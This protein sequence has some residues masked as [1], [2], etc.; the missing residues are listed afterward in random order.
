MYKK[1]LFSFKSIQVELSKDPVNYID[2]GARG[3]LGEPWNML[4]D[5]SINVIG[6]EPDR[7]AFEV[8]CDKAKS[9][10]KYHNIA[11]W[12]S[13]S[14]LKLYLTKSAAASSVFEPN[15]ELLSST[16]ANRHWNTRAVEST[17]TIAT[18]KL[19]SV[20][21]NSSSD[22]MKVDVHG[23]EFQILEGAK[24]ALK[25]TLGV[26]VEAWALEAH[27]GQRLFGDV[28][29]LLY[30]EGFFLHKINSDYMAW[31][32]INEESYG[33]ESSRQPVGI[34]LFFLKRAELI[35]GEEKILKAIV[36]AESYGILGY[37]L[38]L[39]KRLEN[40]ELQLFIEN[41]IKER[42]SN[43]RKPRYKY[44]SLLIQK[45]IKRISKFNERSSSDY[46]EPDFK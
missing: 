3:K 33:A 16:F 29:N 32:N 30:N 1:N 38:S 18:D 20:L 25:G 8:L 43:T 7:K 37:A 15:I 39:N 41:R 26:F 19:D 28:F 2:I 46:Y 24:E 42:I 35:Q 44:Y 45:L 21:S 13:Q 5:S 23:A 22:F 9:N 34:N 27:K 10:R 12:D 6:F 36:I 11:L 14:E 31:K 4:D 40:S 17:T